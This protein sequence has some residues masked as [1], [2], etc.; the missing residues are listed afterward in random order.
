MAEAITIPYALP[1]H[2]AMQGLGEKPKL[3][4]GP[5]SSLQKL[6]IS[7]LLLKCINLKSIIKLLSFFD[8]NLSFFLFMW[9]IQL[10]KY[11]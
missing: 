8:S 7:C 10:Q 5:K 4:Q 3:I 9:N 2:S 1:K 6:R 11:K